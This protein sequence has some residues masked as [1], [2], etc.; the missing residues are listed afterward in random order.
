MLPPSFY[1]RDALEV[2]A[3]LLGAVIRRGPVV[4]R[5]TEV[6]AYRWPDDSANHCRS[7]RT[8]RNA[9]MWG[10]P[11]HAYVY[12]CY[13]IHSMLNLVTGPEGHGAAVL[14]RACAPLEGLE[15]IQARR[16]KAKGPA[17]LAGPGRVGA[18]LGLDTG[19]SGHPL[20][21]E[22][23]LEVRAGRPPEAVLAGP[24][25]G[26][27]YAEPAHRDAPWRLA[28]AGSRWVSQRRGLDRR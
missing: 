27:D 28:A 8:A 5:I 13:G 2:A 22:G 18:A 23:G 20:F 9:P 1:D 6:E 3:A 4:L 25:V 15:T 10:P 24:R 7:G 19:W 17:L 14:I 26:I 12:L 11:G 16:G 21:T